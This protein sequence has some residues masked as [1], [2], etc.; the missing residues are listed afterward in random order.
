M[1]YVNEHL[2]GKTTA[3][4]PEDFPALVNGKR[5]AAWKVGDDWHVQSIMG[6]DELYRMM[7]MLK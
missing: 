1:Y 4:Y 6:G 7:K 5:F 3:R 2:N